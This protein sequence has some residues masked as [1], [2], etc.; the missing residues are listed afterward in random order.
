MVS[1]EKKI[2]SAAKYA[3]STAE[4]LAADLRSATG[5]PMPVAN[6]RGDIRLILDPLTESTLGREG[7]QLE[8][9]G[10]GITL[11]AARPAGQDDLFVAESLRCVLHHLAEIGHDLLHDQRTVGAP[12]SR[13]GPD[14]VMPSGSQA[15]NDGQIHPA[16]GR[17]HEDQHS[18]RRFADGTDEVAVETD[19]VAP[20][21]V[22][23]A[24]GRVLAVHEH[25]RHTLTAGRRARH[26]AGHDQTC[27]GGST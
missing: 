8:V 5:L 23:V 14:H 11:T 25:V 4:L 10:E 24:E 17:V 19:D 18:L 12:I 27:T 15:R 6:D 7:Y 3:E 20:T 26:L 9:A 16:A 2:F 13:V 22:G 21:A 1:L